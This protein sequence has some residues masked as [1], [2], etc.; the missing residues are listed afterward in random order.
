[1]ISR[2]LHGMLYPLTGWMEE[3]EEKNSFYIYKDN[4]YYCTDIDR[5]K[6]YTKVKNPETGEWFDAVWYNEVEIFTKDGTDEKFFRTYGGKQY[7][8]EVSDFKKKFK[9]CPKTK[10]KN[11]KEIW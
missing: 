3:M 7:Y 1:M 10:M 2:I 5:K 4:I 11:M 6:E 9:K 8:R